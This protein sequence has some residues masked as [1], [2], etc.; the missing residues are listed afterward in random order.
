[1]TVVT[2]TLIQTC[3]GSSFFASGPS[4]SSFFASGPSADLCAAAEVSFHL[5]TCPHSAPAVRNRSVL[6]EF[7]TTRR[8]LTTA[9]LFVSMFAIFTVHQMGANKSPTNC[10]VLLQHVAALLSHH[11][12][13]TKCRTKLSCLV[14]PW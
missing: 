9:L 13:E 14:S 11:Q 10:S 2:L 7:V 4:A 3:R 5:V 12:G 1:M 6:A 8:K